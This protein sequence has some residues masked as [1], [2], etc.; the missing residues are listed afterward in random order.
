[1]AKNTGRVHSPYPP[2]GP[3]LPNTRQ[4]QTRRRYQ[5][6]PHSALPHR[7]LSHP[8]NRDGTL[9]RRGILGPLQALRGR[10]H[11]LPVLDADTHPP[12]HPP[13]RTIPMRTLRP[14]EEETNPSPLETRSDPTVQGRLCQ[15]KSISQRQRLLVTQTPTYTHPSLASF[16][17]YHHLEP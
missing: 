13:P 2:R 17:P 6:Q 5:R 15:A 12:T 11:H 9:L 4:W 16:I 3:R 7:Y 10:Q 8:T 1:M 14:H